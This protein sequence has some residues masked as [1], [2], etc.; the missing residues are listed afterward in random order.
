M[1]IE[2]AKR[3]QQKAG[4]DGGHLSPHPAPFQGK[5]EKWHGETVKV[6]AR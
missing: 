3:V 4:A 5:R 2:V 1:F 6:S